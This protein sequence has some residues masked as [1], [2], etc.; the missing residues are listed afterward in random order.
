MTIVDISTLV[1][2][3]VK[4]IPT[5][6]EVGKLSYK[7]LVSAYIPQDGDSLKRKELQQSKRCSKEYATALK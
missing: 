2:T 3:E 5:A 4:T 7:L 1:S 6:Q